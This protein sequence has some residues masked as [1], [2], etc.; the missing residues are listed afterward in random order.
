MVLSQR[1][2]GFVDPDT[3]QCYRWVMIP[4]FDADGLL[5]PGV[6]WAVWDEVTARFGNTP[7]RRQLLEGLGMAINS[8]RRAGCHTV[9]IDGSFVTSK[10]MPNDF[11]AC[12]EE[13][14]VAPELLDPELLHFDAGR[15]AQKARY[16]G[17]LFPA[18]IGATADGMSFLEFFQTDRETGRTKGIVAVDVGGTR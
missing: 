15:A 11:D 3:T 16:Q 1:T 5:P 8:L 13:E 9:Y 7:W 17:E 12:W 18:S 6:H 4:Q 14:G 10:E 2:A